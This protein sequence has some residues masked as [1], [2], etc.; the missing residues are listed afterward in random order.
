MGG[1]VCSGSSIKFRALFLGEITALLHFA[2]LSSGFLPL[3]NL[4]VTYSLREHL[5]ALIDL[6]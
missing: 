4:S 1:S 6:P 3:P 5:R 2:D